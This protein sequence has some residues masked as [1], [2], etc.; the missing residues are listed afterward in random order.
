MRAAVVAG[1]LA[2]VS[3]R[4]SSQA[5]QTAPATQPN[6]AQYIEQLGRAIGQG[7]L[8]H[9]YEAAQ[10]L[11][12]IGTPRTDQLI[13]N[14][15]ADRDANTQKSCVWAAEQAARPDP[16]WIGPLAQLLGKD[17]VATDAAA[18]ALARFDSLPAADA[19]IHFVQ[20]SPNPSFRTSAIGAMGNLVQKSVAEQLV[21]IATTPDEPGEIRRAAEGALTRLSGQIHKPEDRAFWSKWWAERQ[22]LAPEQWRQ[23]MIVERH[24]FVQAMDEQQQRELTRLREKIQKWVDDAYEAAPAAPPEKRNDVLLFYLNDPDPDVRAAA[25]TKIL[26]A[27][28]IAQLIDERVRARLIELISDPSDIVRLDVAEALESLTE[29]SALQPLLNQLRIEKRD[30]IKVWQIRALVKSGND[31]GIVPE[32][33]RLLND[34]SPEVVRAAA[35]ALSKLAGTPNNPLGL[36]VLN[37]LRQTIHNRTGLPGQP[38]P[39]SDPELRAALIEAQAPL[40][41]LLPQESMQRLPFYLNQR[42]SPLVRQATL[43][44]LAVLKDPGVERTIA[45]ELDINI[46]NEADPTVRRT[47]AIA[48]GR[49]GAPGAADQLLRSMYEQTEPDPKV[50]E[51]AWQAL[52]GLMHNMS[53]EAL[54]NRWV[55]EFARG[56]NASAQELQRKLAVLTEACNKLSS[57]GSDPMNLATMQQ[58]AGDTLLKL[59]Q[60]REAIR[61]YLP[62]LD[63]WQKNN[64]QLNPPMLEMAGNVMHAYLLA[65]DY[66]QAAEFAAKQLQLDTHYQNPIGTI[67]RNTVDQLRLSPDPARQADARRLIEAVLNAQL[68]LDSVLLGDLRDFKKSLGAAPTTN[69][70]P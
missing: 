40:V 37:A 45:N 3:A 5:T 12:E 26:Y 41:N 17:Q 30:D 22:P 68:P 35:D 61:Y 8:Q 58:Q 36:P 44:T 60:P 18:G 69:P 11:V 52:Q 43:L 19:L 31:P 16:S 29:A 13:A 23:R 27:V 56:G 57:A 21:K 47:A 15:L 6:V 66:S 48:L 54:V 70:S 63:F 50:R 28:S 2:L 38:L 25:A 39:D 9:R 42:E 20:T 53:A 34:P 4:A 33:E 65:G 67:I 64:A 46:N 10:R 55:G 1:A 7:D 32:L 14:G 62:A 49:S 24:P 59:G 51:A